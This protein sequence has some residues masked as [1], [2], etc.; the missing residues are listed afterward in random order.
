MA[1]KYEKFNLLIKA[2]DDVFKSN[3]NFSFELKGKKVKKDNWIWIIDK[4]N[5]IGQSKVHYELQCND[6]D[7]IAKIVIHF[8]E[9]KSKKESAFISKIE[10]V[11][12]GNTS[13]SWDTRSGEGNTWAGHKIVIL[14]ANFDLGDTD[15]SNLV[16]EALTELDN[17]L[18]EQIRAILKET[19]ST[20]MND[21]KQPLNQI[22]YGPPG[23]GKTYN[24]INR[25]LSIIE[26]NNDDKDRKKL[27]EIF[28][29]YA[30]EGRIVF[31]TFHQSMS[32]EDFIEGIKPETNNEGSVI[33]SVKNGIF[34]E[35]CLRAITPNQTDFDTAYQ[36]LV[37]FFDEKDK[38]FKLELKTS[39]GKTFAVGLNSNNNLSLFTGKNLIKQ[40]TLT[41]ENIQKQIKGED[42][43]V[44]WEGYFS[45]VL[46]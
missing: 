6:D 38:D 2:L 26:P 39:T 18:G 12:H 21:K 22:L 24:T 9:N 29:G 5:Q 1:K 11:S 8:E 10:K 40:G 23:T 25:A 35:L 36:S 7:T 17:T 41:K 34:K 44:G 20:K 3:G 15:I 37:D 4:E 14:N 31:T 28:E 45:G 19:Y 16:Y 33:Y 46:Y 30:D 32:Y 42:K 43:F 27:K 13:I